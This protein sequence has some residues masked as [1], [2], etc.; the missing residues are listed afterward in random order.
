MENYNSA[1]NHVYHLYAH[2]I[3]HKRIK[4]YKYEKIIE[5][6]LVDRISMSN[7]RSKDE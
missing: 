4:K 1:K 2:E 3:W 5:E 7:F 6:P